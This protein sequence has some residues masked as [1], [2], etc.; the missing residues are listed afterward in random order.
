[1]GSAKPPSSNNPPSSPTNTLPLIHYDGAGTSQS[2][3]DAAKRSSTA[4]QMTAVRKNV[5]FTTNSNSGTATAASPAILSHTIVET[6]AATATTTTAAKNQKNGHRSSMDGSSPIT[7]TNFKYLKHV[8]LKFMTS[9]EDEV[10]SI[11]GRSFQTSSTLSS[12]SG[13]PSDPCRI[14]V[15]QFFGRRRTSP[16]WNTRLQNVLV[17]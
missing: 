17:W 14:N 10:R 8:L 7:A 5:T 9:T 12:Y 15:A 3:V 2:D 16:T 6:N 1:M 11:S 4:R 13:D